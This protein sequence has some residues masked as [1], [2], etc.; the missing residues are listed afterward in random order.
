VT[1][2]ELI[3]LARQGNGEA[4]AELVGRHQAV[5]FRTALAAVR[6]PADAEEIA[7]DAFVRAWRSLGQFRGESSFR[8][9]VLR[10]AWNC[11]MSRRRRLFQWW[12]R[13]VP[14]DDARHVTIGGTGA[15][16]R[17]ADEELTR[18]IAAAIEALTPKLRGVLLLAQSGEHQYDEIASMLQIPVGTVKWRV[19][20][21][22]RQV[23]AQLIARGIVD[24]R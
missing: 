17:V 14:I 11:A 8:T 2:D 21:G 18:E 4:F 16:Q 22:R 7:Q 13:E 15:D 1:D 5:V 23:R 20:E 6:R 3:L 9:W 12:R 24:A 10:I 19:A